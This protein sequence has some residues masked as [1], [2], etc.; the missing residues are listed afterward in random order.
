MW[1]HLENQSIIFAITAKYSF[2]TQGI[3]CSEISENHWSAVYIHEFWTLFYF[4]IIASST[5]YMTYVL[6]QM[7][8]YT[9]RK[10]M[11]LE[12]EY[13]SIYYVLPLEL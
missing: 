13:Y 11:T 3:L 6:R 8:I 12:V 2:C 9:G 10:P 4:L 5:F 7:F 1:H